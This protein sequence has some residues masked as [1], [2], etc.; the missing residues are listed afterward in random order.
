MITEKSL[1]LLSL[2]AAVS[3]LILILGMQLCYSQQMDNYAIIDVDELGTG[4]IVVNLN[5]SIAEAIPCIG[6]CMYILDITPGSIEGFIENNTIILGANEEE[7]VNTTITYVSQLGVYKDGQWTINYQSYQNTLLI[8]PVNA[9]PV[10]ITPFPEDFS[11]TSDGR[12]QLYLPP[13]NVTIIYMLSSLPG[14]TTTLPTTQTQET[15]IATETDETETVTTF[16]H[17]TDTTPEPTTSS[18]MY[19]IIIGIIAVLAVVAVAYF[20]TRNRNRKNIGDNLLQYL[21]DR[22]KAI[23]ITLKEK[24]PVTP[25]E[26]LKELDIPRAAFYRRINRLKQAG[27]IEQFEVGGK[28]Y[29][30][31]KEGGG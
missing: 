2:Q 9:L 20:A 23:V 28:V 16:N 8:L 17:E 14:I 6:E 1:R 13:G 4:I 3:I 15:G 10:D 5:V 27:I 21:D 7:M 22:D 19:K 11:Y 25:G 26:L 18:N 29:Y 30:R 31:L 24:G 12:L